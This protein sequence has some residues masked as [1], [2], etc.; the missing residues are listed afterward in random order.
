MSVKFLQYWNVKEEAHGEFDDFLSGCFLPEI[1]GSGL[2]RMVGAWMVASGEGPSFIAEGTADSLGRVEALLGHTFFKELRRRLKTMVQDYSTKLLV[3]FGSREPSCVEMET[4]FKFTQHFNVNAA[5]YFEYIAFSESAHLP[6]LSRY[7]LEIAGVWSVA[8]GATPNV[9][10]ETRTGD[11]ESLGRMLES[12][13]YQAVTL[14]LLRMVTGYGC[15][16]LAPSGHI[17]NR[18]AL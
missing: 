8:V 1:N 6:T 11:P 4:N 18:E 9:I 10:V 3:P 5:D 17:G 7:G 16:A 13:D 14:E 15:K 2:M 12:E